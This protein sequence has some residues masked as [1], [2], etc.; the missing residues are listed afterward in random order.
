MTTQTATSPN[1]RNTSNKNAAV[2]HDLWYP[3]RPFHHQLRSRGS[4]TCTK[5][6]PNMR[7]CIAHTQRRDNRVGE[8][9][10]R[11]AREADGGILQ[12]RTRVIKLSAAGAR[13]WVDE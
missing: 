2:R 1:P 5:E 11:R 8:A 12:R 13:G 3:S 4:C 6:T 9:G 10:G 7:R